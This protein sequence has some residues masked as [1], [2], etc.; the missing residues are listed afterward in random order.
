MHYDLQADKN[1]D[2]VIKKVVGENV[3]EML[4]QGDQYAAGKAVAA[5]TKYFFTFF[6][7]DFPLKMFLI[8]VMGFVIIVWNLQ[9]VMYKLNYVGGC[10]L[11][12]VDLNFFLYFRQE[13]TLLESERTIPTNAKGE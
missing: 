13:L 8:S 10:F 6:P 5:H 2:F 11:N 1:N 4:L 7:R 12:M 3:E 9:I